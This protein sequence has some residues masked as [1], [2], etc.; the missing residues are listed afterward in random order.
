MRESIGG[1]SLL[2]IVIVFAG[3]VI[4]VF[5]GILSYTKAY[6]I[7][8]RIIEIIEKHE[9]YNETIAENEINPDLK[10]AGYDSSTSKD[11][12]DNI[13]TKITTGENLKY[14]GSAL[15][16]NLNENNGYNYCVFELTGANSKIYVVVT[17]IRFEI[18]I[19]NDVLTFPVYGET[20]TLGIDYNY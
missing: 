1:S 4:A 9:D 18:P 13:K 17:F 11:R 12:C 10:A 2:N 3:L 15:T 5:I 6:R 14:E 8:N 20:K 7:K 16:E 19:I